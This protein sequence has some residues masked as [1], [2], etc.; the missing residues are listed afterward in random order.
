M[1]DLQAIGAPSIFKLIRNA[2][3]LA[4][5]CPTLDLS[6]E[7]NTSYRCFFSAEQKKARAEGRKC[8][9]KTI[10][11][12]DAGEAQTCTLIMCRLGKAHIQKDI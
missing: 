10:M 5:M 12:T 2:A 7:E 11:N 4:R 9:A 1:C 3:A 6:C 8:H